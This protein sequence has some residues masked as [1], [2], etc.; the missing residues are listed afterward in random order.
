MQVFLYL[1]GGFMRF[2]EF[3]TYIKIRQ[4]G[5]YVVTLLLFLVVYLFVGDQ[6]MSH[7][8]RRHRE[9]RRLEEQ[10]DTYNA[11]AEQAQREIEVLQHPDSLEQFAREHYFIHAPNEDIFLVEEPE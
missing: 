2:S 5:K 10:R 7:F 4:W 3:W 8:I 11:A 1:C 9:I 6:S